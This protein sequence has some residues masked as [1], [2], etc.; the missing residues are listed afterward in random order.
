MLK[1]Y[2]TEKIFLALCVIKGAVIV[3][4]RAISFIQRGGST[5]NFNDFPV[6]TYL[7]EA[8][9]RFHAANGQLWGYDPHF[10]AGYPLGFIWNSNIAI[11]WLAV[12]FPGTPVLLVVR[13]FFQAG[14]FLFPF[15]WWLTLRNFGLTRRESAFGFLIGSL[16]FMLGMPVLFF[17]AGMLTAGVVTYFSLFA[18]SCIY[19]YARDG[20][21]WWLAA[22]VSLA[23][24]M[25]IH[26][27]AALILLIPAVA[28]FLI[29]L[30]EKKPAR[31]AGLAVAGVAALA[32]NWFWIKTVFTFMHHIKNVSKAP[33]WQNRDLLRPIKDYFMGSIVMN[34]IEFTGAYGVI[35][36]LLLV[37][38]LAVGVVGLVAL[39][40][41]GDRNKAAFIGASACGLWLYSYYGAFLP[42]GDTLNPTRYFP[43]AQ[44]LLAAA[45][46][47]A[48]G[49]M[50][51][52][53]TGEKSTAKAKKVAFIAIPVLCLIGMAYATN[54]LIPIESLL[55][56][57]VDRN[58][59]DLED[60]IK[61]LP[62]GARIM[63]ED[64][65]VMDAD[66]GGQVYG[67]SQ[68]LSHFG[69]ETGKE[70]IGGPYPYM[71]ED[72]HYASFQDG[73]A[74]GTPLSDLNPE[75]LLEKLKLYN[76][77]WIVCW[78]GGA[79]QYF[80]KYDG[81]FRFFYRV[82]RFQFFEVM[83]YMPTYF[84]K[85]SGRISATY[86]RISVS[87]AVPEGGEVIIKYH[88]VPGMSVKP[89][90]KIGEYKISGD[91]NGF[92][93]ITNPPSKFDVYL[94]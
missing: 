49:R 44:L 63:I 83:P 45:A 59:T 22:A 18:A 20:G 61:E 84:L 62:G 10:M 93:K 53:E 43:V 90:A 8:A 12:H 88:W 4:G 41:R 48:L 50:N 31:A 46:G 26:K 74:F 11:Q 81:Y 70:F 54:R 57:P 56:F 73:E 72:Y 52:S 5:L 24:A 80:T 89:P 91:P 15:F 7:A 39:W 64:S 1:K 25:F 78:S 47:I 68:I 94:K 40:R 3:I 13:W 27:T 14:V 58:V 36:S 23:L 60:R 2:K 29:A 71:F 28:A 16:Y 38:L 30:K 6:M 86:N 55:N 65:G 32:V 42:G 35:H 75:A 69:L 79:A 51:S 82:G 37:F 92:I 87:D 9:R 34:N 67:K 77:K 66:G 33:F 19:R 17:A 76:V 85:G 21:A